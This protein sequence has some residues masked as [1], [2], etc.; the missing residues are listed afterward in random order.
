VEDHVE[1]DLGM[2]ALISDRGLRHHRN[3]DAGN[4][5]IGGDRAAVVV[6]DGVSSTANPDQAAAA[7][8]EAAMAVLQAFLA[9][10]APDQAEDEDEEHGDEED[11]DEE[12]GAATV[13]ALREAVDAA[14]HAV[15]DV[16]GTEAGGYPGKPS[17]T[18][19]A[20]VIGRGLA[21][22]ASVGDSRGYWLA[23]GG[24]NQRL[25]VDDSWA[26]A[27]IASGVPEPA[28][29]AA[30]QAH[31]ITSWIGGD[32]GD[33]DP[34]VAT[35]RLD[36]A[37]VVVVC[38]DGLWNYLPGPDDLAAAADTG[39][40]APEGVSRP[41]AVARRLVDTALQA[42]GSDNITVAVVIVGPAA[43]D[44]ED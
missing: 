28:A 38:S 35:V 18:L 21:V 6:C 27:A 1:I 15:D 20:G 24:T 16:P 36:E 40:P 19:V 9:E 32:A 7:A 14:R 44:D 29:Y 5:V 10:P 22:M 41:L 31:V 42:G 8:T 17:T 43:D 39:A 13:A 30:P 12:D 26:E 25:T 11:G 34:A 33:V 37:G 23:A 4:V 2:A 3:E